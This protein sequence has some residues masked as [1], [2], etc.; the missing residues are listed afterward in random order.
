MSV[1]V[2]RENHDLIYVNEK[3][4]RQDSDGNWLSTEE[5]T[6]AENRAFYEYL[7]SEKLNRENRLN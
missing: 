2:K 7:N 4:V 5:L 1:K 3:I 6:T